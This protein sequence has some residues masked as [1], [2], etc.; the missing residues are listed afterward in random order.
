MSD[1]TKR[2][3]VLLTALLLAG[4]AARAA[5]QRPVNGFDRVTFELPGQLT[6]QQGDDF[7]LE[8]DAA[9]EDLER[10]ETRVQGGELAIGWRD[11]VFGWAGSRTHGPIAIRLT[12]P[13]LRGLEVAGSGDVAAGS[14][15]G[16]GLEVEVNGSG[17]VA[18][19]ELTVEELDLEI[20]GSGSV[21]AARVDTAVV[22]IEVLGSGSV[23]LAGAADR[24][25]IEVMGSGDVVLTELEGARVNVEI[26][27]SGDVSVWANELL[28]TE[29]MGSG[30]VSY[31][32]TPKVDL[33][34]HGPGRLRAL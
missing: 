24:Q 18:F 1:L 27:G 4:A 22:R 20:A 13:E 21:E 26:M 25:E 11:G 19:E 15:L 30:D 8:I 7:A 2:R 14:W 5:E 3:F 33:E 6:L 28:T 17:S 29:I 10:I 34:K 16:E 31:R 9:A 32:G 23:Q 12:L